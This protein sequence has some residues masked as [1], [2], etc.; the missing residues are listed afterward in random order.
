MDRQSGSVAGTLFGVAIKRNQREPSIWGSPKS[1]HTQNA[2]WKSRRVSCSSCCTTA[3]RL[4]R[5][6][7]QIPFRLRQ[8]PTLTEI[9]A[10]CQ[11]HSRGCSG[12][13]VPAHIGSRGTG[14]R[15]FRYDSIKN[16]N[17][18]WKSQSKPDLF[19]RRC[20]GPALLLFIFFG[21]G[22]LLLPPPSKSLCRTDTAR[23]RKRQSFIPTFGG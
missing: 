20:P 10:R 17:W 3:T 8:A 12:Y 6:A 15:Q 14:K 1:K 18:L 5:T 19:E 2:A 13:E 9:P 11:H 16:L 21:G 22:H 4:V 23:D 7:C